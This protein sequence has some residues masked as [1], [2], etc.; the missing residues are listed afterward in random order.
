MGTLGHAE[1]DVVGHDR[2]SYVAMRLALDAPGAV[3]RLAVLDSVPIGEALAR[4]DA[5]FARGVV[6]LVLLRAAGQARARDP[7]R[8]RRLVRRRPGADGRGEPR[9]LPARDPRSR[10]RAGD[11]RGLPRRAGRR[12][13][14]R[15]RGSGGGAAD[16]VP[17]AGALVHPGR[18][19]E[20][21]GDVPAVWRPWVAGTLDGFAIDSGHHMAEDAPDELAAALLDFLGETDPVDPG[22]DPG[23]PLRPARLVPPDSVCVP[24]FLGAQ[25]RPGPTTRQPLV[26]VPEGSPWLPW[27]PSFPSAPPEPVR[28]S[29]VRGVLEF[30]PRT[31]PHASRHAR[32]ASAGPRGRRDPDVMARAESAVVEQ[33][34]PLADRIA[35]RYRGRGVE[36]DDLAATRPV[37]AVQGG[38][39]VV[40]ASAARR[41]CSSPR[42]RSRAR[43]SATSGTSAGRSACRGRCRRT[44]PSTSTWRVS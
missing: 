7:R 17:D 33:Y 25:W 21:Y 14:R 15:R 10:D 35:R 36:D 8:S 23:S 2:G 28:C 26:A 18:H 42:R 9:R 11:A 19:G 4:A 44:S 24:R 22:P 29:R 37:R 12:P 16:L 39:P 30:F 6:A 13:G 20:L 41:S 3:R 32:T 1:F 31:R 40:P 27:L 38:A 43:S 34:R 5:R